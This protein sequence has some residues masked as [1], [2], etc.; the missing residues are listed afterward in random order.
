MGAKRKLPVTDTL[1][2]EQVESYLTSRGFKSNKVSAS[3]EDRDAELLLR[4]GVVITMTR[5]AAQVVEGVRVKEG[6]HCVVASKWGPL[7]LISMPARYDV[8]DLLPDI[9]AL[10][11][12]A[13]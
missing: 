10:K 13:P 3:S 6:K 9:A 1:T 12:L 4:E 11:E 8:R 5:A 7:G 2:I